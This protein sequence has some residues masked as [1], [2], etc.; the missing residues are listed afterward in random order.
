MT[1]AN[2][3]ELKN[4]GNKEFSAG[5]Y[6]KAIELFSQAIDVDSGN[7]VQCD[8]WSSTVTNADHAQVLYSNRSAAYSSL[9]DYENALKDAEKCV[10]IKPDWSKG[11]GRKGAA[12]FGLNRLVEA[13][14]SYSEGLKYDSS[15]AMLKKGLEDVNSSMRQSMIL[16]LCLKRWMH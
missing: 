8:L 5:N 11:Y 16:W 1:T 4:A 10:S 9:K 3:E 12:L 13:E 2:A 7:H 14:K 6:S 15:N